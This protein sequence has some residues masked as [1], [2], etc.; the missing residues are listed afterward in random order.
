MPAGVPERPDCVP[1][2]G[3]LQRTGTDRA[4]WAGGPLSLLCEG[5]LSPRKGT[6]AAGHW[7]NQGRPFAVCSPWRGWPGGRC[8]GRGRPVVTRW[9][10]GRV[11]EGERSLA[12]SLCRFPGGGLTARFVL[13]LFCEMSRSI[14]LKLRRFLPN[15]NSVRCGDHHPHSSGL[16]RPGLLPERGTNF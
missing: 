7:C 8:A 1:V 3:A 5:R 10:S 12:S 13:L 15:E 11:P 16:V 14:T 6:D 9:E 2:P 4:L